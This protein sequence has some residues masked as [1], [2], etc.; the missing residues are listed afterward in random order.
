MYLI[1]TY[2]EY[3]KILKEWEDSRQKYS[4]IARERKFL[5]AKINLMIKTA[6]VSQQVATVLYPT[7]EGHNLENKNI[8]SEADEDE[9]V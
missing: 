3:M 9:D 7:T 6:K 4:I 2:Q 8:D 1:F 5:R